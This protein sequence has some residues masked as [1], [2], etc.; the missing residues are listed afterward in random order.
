MPGIQASDLKKAHNSI[1]RNRLIGQ[2]FYSVG[3]IEKWGQGTLKI[4]KFCAAFNLPEP[5]YFDHPLWVGIVLRAPISPYITP[6]NR[7]APQLRQDQILEVLRMHKKL[8]AKDLSGLLP[9]FSYR[10]IQR[11]L[12]SLK[13]KKLVEVSGIGT[14]S[15]IWTLR[16]E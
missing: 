16:E 11:E 10:T 7:R 6:D 13:D 4:A 5:E 14:T 8:T 3:Y 2:V 12:S 1:L 9:V 15:T